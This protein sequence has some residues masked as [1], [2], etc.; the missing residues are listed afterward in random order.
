L[1]ASR[2]HKNYVNRDGQRL[3]FNPGS[4]MA[5]DR[6]IV[7]SSGPALGEIVSEGALIGDQEQELAR[8]KQR[9]RVWLGRPL[10][11]MRI[12]LT[13]KQP[14]AGYP[15]HAYYGCRFAYRDER[16]HL[17]RGSGGVSHFTTHPRP[18][19]PDYLDIRFGPMGTEIFP[20]GL[21]FHT[22]QEGRMLDVILIPEG[23]TATTFD[24]GLA[25]DRDQPMLTA[26]GIASPL[27]V[28]PT[29]KG[30]PHIGSSGWLF[31]FDL[32]SLLLTRML[33]ETRERVEGTP[34]AEPRD[35]IVAQLLECS[36]QSAH[37]EMRC[38]RNPTRAVILD[39]LGRFV[40]NHHF[41]GDMISLEVA[42]H[43]WV[44]LQVEF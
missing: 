28:V 30:P 20:G 2:D 27:A 39:G 21:P 11:E 34:P 16:T 8:F 44:Q 43:E 37:S 17:F 1:K 26:W 38:L 9:F 18:Q 10:L 32:P 22:K 40:L 3:V 4:R 5:A 33:P 42:P 35:A 13:P 6:V 24:I 14:A 29:T 19:S 15:W 31:H 41:S 36:G 7:T 12:E 25:L 23:E